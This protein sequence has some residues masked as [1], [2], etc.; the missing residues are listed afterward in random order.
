MTAIWISV[1]KL[2]VKIKLVVAQVRV[3]N[4][5]GGDCY[6]EALIISYFHFLSFCNEAKRGVDFRYSTRNGPGERIRQ[7]V[8]KGMSLQ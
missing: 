7:K 5:C 4:S 6:S 1:Y 8:R 2:I 3:R